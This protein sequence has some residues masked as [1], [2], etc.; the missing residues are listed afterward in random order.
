MKECRIGSM[1]EVMVIL[2]VKSRNTI[3][4]LEKKLGFPKRIK[5][6]IRRVGYDLNEVIEWLQSR[7][8]SD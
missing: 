7:K 6:G 2:G 5:I 4:A 8:I 1:D 3:Y